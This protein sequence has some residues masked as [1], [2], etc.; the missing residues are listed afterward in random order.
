MHPLQCCLARSNSSTLIVAV[1]ALSSKGPL[2]IPQ[3]QNCPAVNH[4]ESFHLVYP[5]HTQKQFCGCWFCGGY[6]GVVCFHAVC[7]CALTCLCMLVLFLQQAAISVKCNDL[8]TP[9]GCARRISVASASFRPSWSHT[10]WVWRSLSNM[11]SLLDRLS[12]PES[13][14][15]PFTSF[16]SGETLSMFFTRLW[17]NKVIC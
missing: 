6:F 3:D 4:S 2:T 13:R 5:M 14:G 8:P 15:Q 9:G 10:G 16:F 12:Y 11:L 1:Y 17:R 7:E